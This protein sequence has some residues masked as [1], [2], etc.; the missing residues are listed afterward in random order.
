MAEKPFGQ[1]ASGRNV[2]LDATFSKTRFVQDAID[3]A[4]GASADFRIIECA[5]ADDVA[6]ERISKRLKQTPLK[7]GP[8]SDIRPHLFRLQKKGFE[9]ISLPCISVDTSLTPD[10]C[11]RLALRKLFC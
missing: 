1:L 3:A 4:K 7:K 5:C 11:V 8:V 2:V 6:M 9:G 10:E